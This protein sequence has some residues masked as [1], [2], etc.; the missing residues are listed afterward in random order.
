M[1]EGGEY[2]VMGRAL[3]SQ[4]CGEVAGSVFNLLMDM[5]TFY[6]QLRA[7]SLGPALDTEG[8]PDILII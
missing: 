1:S 8:Y 3:F 4:P 6:S 2:L 7:L 5:I